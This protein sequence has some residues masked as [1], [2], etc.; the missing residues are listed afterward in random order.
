MKKQTLSNIFVVCGI[1][2]LVY[3]IFFRVNTL[4]ELLIM[5]LCIAEVIIIIVSIILDGDKNVQEKNKV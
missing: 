5:N 2:A 4:N 3:T 1:L